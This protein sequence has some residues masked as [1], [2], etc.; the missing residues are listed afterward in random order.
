[1]EFTLSREERRFLIKGLYDQQD[2][3][4]RDIAELKAMDTTQ[5]WVQ[6]ELIKAED[7]YNQLYALQLKLEG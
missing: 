3:A 5:Q 1:M 6:I 4:L 7:K 2:Y